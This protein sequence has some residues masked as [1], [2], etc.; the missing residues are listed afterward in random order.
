MLI[1]TIEGEKKQLRQILQ[2]D[3]PPQ[4]PPPSPPTAPHWSRS[5]LEACLIE[6]GEG[7]RGGGGSIPILGPAMPRKNN[8]TPRSGPAGRGN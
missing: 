1:L 8:K 3:T 6:A 4:S 2:Y 5:L 7:A